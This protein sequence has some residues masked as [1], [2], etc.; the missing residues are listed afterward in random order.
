[1]TRRN[2]DLGKITH[3]RHFFFFLPPSESSAASFTY[4]IIYS[5]IVPS[6]WVGVGLVFHKKAVREAEDAE[7]RGLP[8]RRP[9]A[10]PGRRERE[11]AKDSSWVELWP[12]RQPR[13]SGQ[14]HT[15][16]HTAA[17]SPAS[18][19]PGQAVFHTRHQKDLPKTSTRPLRPPFSTSKASG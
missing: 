16:V 6:K 19:S 17:S 8:L 5:H 10:G 2:P 11:E 7:V 9:Q 18:Q 13:G 15:G 12:H 14:V 4:F 3:P 1:M